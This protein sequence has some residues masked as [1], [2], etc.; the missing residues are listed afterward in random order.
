MILALAYT[1]ALVAPAVVRAL[2][3]RDLLLLAASTAIAFF[4][5]GHA[6]HLARQDRAL[7]CARQLHQERV[8]NAKEKGSP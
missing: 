6:V 3:A 8:K 5:I 1:I 7:Q 4:S 2:L